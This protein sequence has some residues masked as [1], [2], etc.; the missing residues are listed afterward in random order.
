MFGN[1]RSDKTAMRR[2]LSRRDITILVLG[3]SVTKLCHDG[4]DDDDDDDDNS[5]LHLPQPFSYCKSVLTFL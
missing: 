5:N 4:D 2:Y 3:S 1:R